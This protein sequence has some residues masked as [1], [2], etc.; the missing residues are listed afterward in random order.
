MVV[1]TFRDDAMADPAGP[2]KLL[3]RGVLVSYFLIPARIGPLNT[4]T[5]VDFKPETIYK[6]FT[7]ISIDGVTD[8]ASLSVRATSKWFKFGFEVKRVDIEDRNEL[9]VY[10][11]TMTPFKF[12]KNEPLFEVSLL[13]AG[14]AVEV[15]EEKFLIKPEAPASSPGTHLK[16][17]MH[18]KE[19]IPAAAQV[20]S[21]EQVVS[22]E[23][24]V[25]DWINSPDD[26]KEVAVE[27]Q[28]VPREYTG[29][30]GI[31]NTGPKAESVVSEKLSGKFSRL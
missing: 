30:A 13:S 15:A 22:A 17:T 6:I 7:G 18:V 16:E 26:G 9:V 1:K 8:P 10:V 3:V 23:K 11:T 14:K 31:S 24:R 27:A 5:E 12:I 20:Q 28:P 2:G 25:A 19:T 29:P 4:F 21:P